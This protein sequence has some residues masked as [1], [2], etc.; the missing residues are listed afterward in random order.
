MPS[1]STCRDSPSPGR[2][3]PPGP[4]R[5][6]HRADRD[7]GSRLCH[8]GPTV[9]SASALPVSPATRTEFAGTRRARPTVTVLAGH[10]QLQV[11]LNESPGP[12][13]LAIHPSQSGR[14]MI[15]AT[16]S[17][18]ASGPQLR[19]TRSVPDSDSQ[20]PDMPPSQAVARRRGSACPS[21]PVVTTCR[22]GAPRLCASSGWQKKFDRDGSVFRLIL[23]SDAR[24]CE[25]A[26]K[27]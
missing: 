16:G 17:L 26:H 21:L 5:A 7:S 25:A 9:T 15:R 13:S 2:L 22:P 20:L 19:L 6:G 8:G 18:R 11:Q 27:P 3:P 14:C 10:W 4:G 12:G 1:D 24:R 23:A